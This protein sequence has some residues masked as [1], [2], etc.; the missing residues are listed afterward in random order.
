MKKALGVMAFCLSGVAN[1]SIV[2]LDWVT[3]ASTLTG[4]IPG[5]VGEQITTTFTVD[6]GGSSILSQTWGTADF[7]SYRVAG[8]SGWWIESNYIDP[9]LSVFSTD[10]L[11]NVTTAAMWYGGYPSANITTSWAGVLLGGWW[12]NGNNQVVCSA[13]ATDC[14]WANNVS[15]NQ[16]GASW[17][18]TLA[19]AEP[20]PVPASMALLGLGFAALGFAG[21]RK[22]A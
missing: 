2:E 9:G 20:V 14:V 21:R 22:K 1:A 19:G 5:V 10:A 8:A 15:E 11:G 4:S 3:T 17:T 16:V 13:G 6:N 18:A 12:N 7:V